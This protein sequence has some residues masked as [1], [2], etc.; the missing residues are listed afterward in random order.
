MLDKK[1]CLPRLSRICPSLES[2][3]VYYCTNGSATASSPVRL[4][5]LSS[6]TIYSTK[7][8]APAALDLL[9]YSPQLHQVTLSSSTS[10]DRTALERLL[11]GGSLLQVE[12]LGLLEAPLLDLP[13]LEEL[14]ERLPLLRLVGRL[15]GWA[16]TT[17]QL[18]PL[19]K[20][21]RRENYEVTLWYNLPIPA[22]LPP[23]V[24]M[25]EDF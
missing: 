24:D 5:R 6:V 16:I 20:R 11:A 17:G 8:S 12:E 7:L 3:E 18:E 4:P 13:C 22:Q 14:I 15:E 25:M 1:S 10:L 2:L 21:L 19:R 9:E 23:G